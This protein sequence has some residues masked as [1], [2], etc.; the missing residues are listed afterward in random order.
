V[1]PLL[2][3]TIPAVAWLAVGPAA[4]TGALAGPGRGEIQV[5]AGP[6]AA[7]AVDAVPL[8]DPGEALGAAI[9]ALDG[10]P[11]CPETASAAGEPRA[12]RA[13]TAAGSTPAWYRRDGVLDPAGTLVGWE[14]T[15]QASG[16]TVRVALPPEAAA[17]GPVGGQIVVA[18]DDGTRS[19]VRLVAPGRQCAELVHASSDVVRQ[20][21]VAPTGEAL[22]FHAVG[23]VDRTD[24]GVWHLPFG[25]GASARL[26]LPPLD[27]GGPVLAAIG[28]VWTTELRASHDGELLAVESC[29]EVACRTRL[30]PIGGRRQSPRV[31]EVAGPVVGLDGQLL[32]RLDP[33]DGQGCVLVATALT[34]GRDR[35]LAQG[36]SSATTLVVDGRLLAV[37]TRSTG[38]ALVVVDPATG[39]T[40]TAAGASDDGRPSGPS[41]ALRLLPWG[42][43]ADAGSEVSRG[44]VAATAATTRALGGHLI[45]IDVTGTLAARG[46][47]IGR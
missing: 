42:G 24:R 28:R 34:S 5:E 2:V 15:A 32:V 33:C 9:V 31:T 19:E 23:R 37:G 29:G 10:L 1:S 18:S 36:I 21:I 3:S 12:G 30:A 11:A 41:A 22:L 47:E 7:S 43:A 6:P 38:P 45:S 39:R 4:S 44:A 26:L 13:A 17:R 14:L 8:A 20:A 16:A 46:A 27:P 25:N 35:P 40:W